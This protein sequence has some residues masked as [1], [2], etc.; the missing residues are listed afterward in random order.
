MPI[1]T[2]DSLKQQLNQS[3][4]LSLPSTDGIAVPSTPTGSVS[5]TQ[6]KIDFPMD[7]FSY[8][9]S[10]VGQKSDLNTLLSLSDGDSAKKNNYAGS[11]LLFNSDRIVINSRVDY[12]MLFGQAGVAIS[13]PGNVNIDADDGI[14]L[15][16]EDGLYL[17]VP[18]KG[19]SLDEGGGV[20]KMPK[21][22][23]EATLDEDYEPLVLGLKLVNL[24]EDLL[25]TIK[26]A[27]ILTPTGK[28]YFRED[29]MY[30]LACLQ[31]RLPEMLST[32][33]Y[34]DGISHEMPDPAPEPPST[35][36]ETTP[37]TT[38]TTVGPTS[39]AGT[40]I[41]PGIVSNNTS[42]PLQDQPNYFETQN[43]YDDIN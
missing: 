36:S 8:E 39:T 26:N 4:A 7:D 20:K 43:P 5:P 1:V 14:T 9:S 27:T 30:E 10:L 19:K 3:D 17:G 31:A 34:I 35:V 2:Y 11:Q 32:Y 41:E 29:T 22:K 16:G 23:A 15:F 37:Q 28:A 42:G 6:P 33:G 21:T 18:G 13:S 38:G 24:L 40:S 25:I 12:L